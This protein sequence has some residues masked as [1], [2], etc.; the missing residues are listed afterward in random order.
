M[1][2]EFFEFAPNPHCIFTAQGKIIELNTAMSN[3]LGLARHTVLATNLL[4]YLLPEDQAIMTRQLATL[5]YVHNTQVENRCR[6]V[7]GSYRWLLWTIS[8]APSHWQQE[9]QEQQLYYGVASDI[10]AYKSTQP[11]LNLSQQF[12][13]SEN[14]L[15]IFFNAVPVGVCVTDENG[16]FV[17][18]NPAYCK[19]Y[20]YSNQ[21]LIGQHFTIVVQ[22]NQR[23]QL[24]KLH[25][26]CI[27]EGISELA[28]EWQ[29][30]H[31]TGRLIDI[32]VNTCVIALPNGKR[33]KITIVND[34]SQHK[35]EQLRRNLAEQLLKEQLKYHRSIIMSALDGFCVLDM[36]LNIKEV[37]HAFCQLLGYS[38]DLLLNSCLLSL[39]VP[40]EQSPVYLWLQKL[41]Q[42]AQTNLNLQLKHINGKLIE[43][44][45]NSNLIEFKDKNYIFMFVR[46]AKLRREVETALRQAKESAEAAN[47]SKSEFLATMSHE[48][49]TPMN[50]VMGIAEL[51]LDTKL[52][53]QQR[54]Y[55]NLIR[56]SGEGLLTVISDV[57]DFA[58]IEAGK[59]KL[60]VIEFDL[61][62]LL[63]EVVELF[64][65]PANQKG[66]NMA[67]IFP[68]LLPNLLL[69]DPGRL[70]QILTNLLGN[71]IKF[72]EYG[73]IILTVNLLAE[74]NTDLCLRF[75]IK[76]TGIGISAEDN[77]RLFQPFGQ[78]DSSTTRQYGGTG[79]GLMICQ[80]LV[81]MMNGKLGVDSKP[82][83]GSRFWFELNFKKSTNVTKILPDMSVLNGL[84]VLIIDDN[85]T[86]CEILRDQSK[87]WG[88][89]PEIANNAKEG[90][91]KIYAALEQQQF[92]DLA[93]IDFMMPQMDGISLAQQIKQDQQ[94]S[95]LP[96]IMLTSVHQ[97]IDSSET[98]DLL[99]CKLYKPVAQKKLLT[100]LLQAIEQ[101]PHSKKTKPKKLIFERAW[102]ILLAED[103]IINQEVALDM[104]KGLGCEVQV[105]DNGID[106]LAKRQEHNY[107]L[108]F[109]DCHMPHM[110]GFVATQ[111]IRIWENQQQQAHSIIVALT[112]NAMQ[113]DRERCL[114]SGMDDYISKPVTTKALKQMISHWLAGDMK[115]FNEPVAE[116]SNITQA[117]TQKYTN[118]NEIFALPLVDSKYLD[119]L[120][121]EMKGRGVGWLIEL[122]LTELPNYLTA[123]QNAVEQQDSEQIYLA[124]H[125]FKGSSAN[126]GAQQ[127]VQLCKLVEGKAKQK[128]I[129]Q[130]TELMPVVL[131]VIEKLKQALN[132]EKDKS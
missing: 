49:R 2:K 78:L 90:L 95:K 96:L 124:A 7:D 34:I 108:I 112:A 74:I 84:K 76:D 3:L 43:V 1:D 47:R 33:Y 100:C 45:I 118:L 50:G 115:E 57:L 80:R 120:R 97:S 53:A 110:D 107:D 8:I 72:T 126:L 55:V 4:H 127:L 111:K 21:E 18:V 29:V 26:R 69:G 27:G 32:A 85:P 11:V 58:K 9:Y 119:G 12:S 44:E 130:I 82:N 128:Q 89:I 79:L 31:K 13:Q 64:T 123:V 41:K 10:S 116:H 106:A 60:E 67:C 37:N 5:D 113:G 39:L 35:Q 52:T 40:N 75:E 22:P 99:V 23:E 54:H 117:L 105:V 51:L 6:Q 62:T 93:I 66:L 103:N 98:K 77:L 70:R 122:Y 71:A 92:Y 73:E 36:E 16:I 88:L 63:E 102:K 125:K 28:T 17:Q 42:Q 132:L 56:S 87:N 91:N 46:D 14:F 94:I 20:G 101:Q 65:P 24:H 104:L 30:M 131:E 109:M 81:S 19:I 61:A 121:Q 59:L 25:A 68:P 83:Q 86:N 48:I 15:A 129:Q 114:A 38:E